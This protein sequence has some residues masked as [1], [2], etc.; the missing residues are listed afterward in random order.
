[1]ARGARTADDGVVIPLAGRFR[2]FSTEH[3]VLLV[4]FVLGCVGFAL[5]GR[6][7]R[8]T[9]AERRV[10]LTMAVAIPVFTVPLQLLQF[11]PRDFTMGTSLPLQVC[12]LSW[13]VATYALLSRSVR[14]NQLLYY[15]ATLVLQAILTPSLQQAFPD[16]RFFMFWGMHFLTMW[17]MVYLT[18]GLGIRPTWRGYRFAVVVTAI[19]A[20]GVMV[21]NGL[22]GTNYGYLNGKPSVDTLL[23][24]LGP[25]PLYVVL[26]IG[27]VMAA[28]ALITWPWVRRPRLTPDAPAAAAAHHR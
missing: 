21:F 16:P 8:G 26:E 1:M 2:A 20:A 12:D 6:R 18:F 4:L 11:V 22:T 7:L 9:P 17:A 13:M 14:A 28:W 5:L 19:W 10:R 3:D 27:I 24:L 25:W 15:W 23:D